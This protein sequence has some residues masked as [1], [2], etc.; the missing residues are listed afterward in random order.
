METDRRL[1]PDID[2]PVVASCAAL[3]YH[4]VGNSVRCTVQSLAHV[5]DAFFTNFFSIAFLLNTG[6]ILAYYLE[7]QLIF[8]DCFAHNCS[9]KNGIAFSSLKLCFSV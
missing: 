6:A 1:K 4:N 5:S 9:I 3:I 2:G 8:A 7:N